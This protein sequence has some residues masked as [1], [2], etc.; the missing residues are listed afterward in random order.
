LFFE[1]ILLLLTLLLG[2]V[3]LFV[4]LLEL[5]VRGL[6]L[7]LAVKKLGEVF[8]HLFLVKDL[9]VYVYL[10]RVLLSEV[11]LALE[12]RGGVGWGHLALTDLR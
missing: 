9:H 12:L 7:L 11:R 6:R 3:D 2:L 8:G 4:P 10:G 5:P 1:Q